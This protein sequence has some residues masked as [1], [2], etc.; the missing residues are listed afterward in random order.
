MYNHI[1]TLEKQKKLIGLLVD[2]LFPLTFTKILL[3]IILEDMREA[4]ELSS[5]SGE[6]DLEEQDGQDQET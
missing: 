1:L 3:K 5:R 4:A 6:R 2:H